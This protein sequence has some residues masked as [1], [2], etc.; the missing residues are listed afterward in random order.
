MRLACWL[1]RRAATLFP[2]FS[3]RRM[4]SRVWGSPRS[5]G[6]H[7][8]RR[9]GTRRVRYPQLD[10]ASRFAFG[11]D[12]FCVH[13]R[14]VSFSGASRER[15]GSRKRSCPDS[16]RASGATGRL[17]PRRYRWVHERI[18]SLKIDNLYFRRCAQTR[19]GNGARSLP[20]KIFRSRENG[21][22]RFFRSRDHAVVIRFSHG[23]WT[24]EIGARK[25]S[26]AR[27]LHF[28]LSQ[29]PAFAGLAHSARSYVGGTIAEVIR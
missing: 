21:D 19:L 3:S 25:R 2:R 29:N 18:R 26:A 23:A 16:L 27:A 1:P 14:L 5:R 22:A 10:C 9:R 20:K 12:I 24:L 11:P 28:D 6:R 13:K 8:S 7:R 17:E 15:T 4:G